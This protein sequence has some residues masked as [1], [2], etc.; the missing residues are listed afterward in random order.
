MLGAGTQFQTMTIVSAD[1]QEQNVLIPVSSN[2]TP[3]AVANLQT[4]TPA[5]SQ[6]NIITQSAGQP[7]VITSTGQI[8]N[9]ASFQAAVKSNSDSH[10]PMNS[11][12]HP[13]Q[14]IQFQQPHLTP[15]V[16]HSV[17]NIYIMTCFRMFNLHMQC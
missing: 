10:S 14:T 16:R 9:L 12:S 4:T 17:V 15:Q 13:I 3:S 1:G 5:T 6:S 8:F 2:G 7:A 11:T